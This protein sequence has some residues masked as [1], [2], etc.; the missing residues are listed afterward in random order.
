MQSDPISGPMSDHRTYQ[1]LEARPTRTRRLWSDAV[2]ERIISEACAPGANVSAIARS[3]EMAPSQLF[4]WRR[5]AQ[6]R[7]A[8]GAGSTTVSAGST[9]ETL[10]FVE[11]ASSGDGVE[12]PLAGVCELHISD[13]TIRVGEE[14]CVER[15]IDLIR[16][17]RRA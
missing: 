4:R 10:S 16:A 2:R 1:L 6:R 8:A 7:S 9:K 13:T 14:V 12:R 17:V 11:I 5:E 15:I 3:Y